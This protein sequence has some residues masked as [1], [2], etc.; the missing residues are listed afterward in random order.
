MVH[1][2]RSSQWRGMATSIGHGW[3]VGTARL[4][5]RWLLVLGA[6]VASSLAIGVSADLVKSPA[7]P[8][9]PPSSPVAQVLSYATTWQGAQAD[10]LITLPSGIQVKSSNYQGVR[11]GNT[12]YYYDLSP[13]PSFDPLSRGVLDEQQIHVVAIVGDS[14]RRVMIY[15]ANS[16][17]LEQASQSAP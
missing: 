9:L 4:I 1:H 17:A 13:Y 6:I 12:I 15:T 3:S 2:S 7:P 8:P 14:P 16:T 11:I 5:G 10:P